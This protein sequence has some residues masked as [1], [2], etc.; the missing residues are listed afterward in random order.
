MG[1]K[2]GMPLLARH[3]GEW[4]G[5]FKFLDE[6]SGKIVEQYD[7]HLTITFPTDG[8]CDYQQINQYYDPDG[9][10]L[11]KYVFPGF[12]DGHG[13]LT[14]D[15]ERLK[16]VTWELDENAMY[17]YWTYKAADTTLDQRLFELIVLSDDG[18]QRS[19]TVQWLENGLCVKRSIIKETLVS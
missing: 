8:S 13:R 5:V 2:R 18:K 4:K 10:E 9:K 6:E 11:A 19:R 16:G 7:S 12:Y 15:S 1:I 3:E 14:F 17:L